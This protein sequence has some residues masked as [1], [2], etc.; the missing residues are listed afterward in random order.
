MLAVTGGGGGLPERR[1]RMV[2][3]DDFPVE[4]SYG[5]VVS[6]YC[7]PHSSRLFKHTLPIYIIVG[8]C[9]DKGNI[10]EN[11]RNNKILVYLFLNQPGSLL[12]LHRTLLEV[13]TISRAGSGPVPEPEPQRSVLLNYTSLLLKT[14]KKILKFFIVSNILTVDNYRS[15]SCYE[16]GESSVADPWHFG[17][18]PD[19]RI[20]TFKFFCLLLFEGTYT[21]HFSKI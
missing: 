10:W 14:D 17:T 7:K 3:K 1:C 21:F 9:H 12:T 6:Q 4:L 5:S 8:S 2:R 20:H 16:R 19:P 11:F 18:D 15:R 13:K